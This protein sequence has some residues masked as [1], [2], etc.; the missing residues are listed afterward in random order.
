L[1]LAYGL[2]KDAYILSE[3]TDNTH[4]LIGLAGK[5]F[6][7]TGGIAS[8]NQNGQVSNEAGLR[9][10]VLRAKDCMAAYYPDIFYK[11]PVD[12]FRICYPTSRFARVNPQ[13][14]GAIQIA[15][16]LNEL[17]ENMRTE[18]LRLTRMSSATPSLV[19]NEIKVSAIESDIGRMLHADAGTTSLR[20]KL[21]YKEAAVTS[22]LQ[23]YE[24]KNSIFSRKRLMAEALMSGEAEPVID[25]DLS[26]TCPDVVASDISLYREALIAKAAEYPIRHILISLDYSLFSGMYAEVTIFFDGDIAAGAVALANEFG[27]C[28]ASIAKGGGFFI[29]YNEKPNQLTGRFEIKDADAFNCLIFILKC[30]AKKDQFFFPKSAAGIQTFFWDQIPVEVNDGV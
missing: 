5:V 27:E 13:K 26:H 14:D 30:A 22:A 17:A 10:L 21:M 4:V 7:S 25:I 20:L 28:W 15:N 24:V 6:S 11:P 8:L 1:R 2:K 19:K 3:G 12:A 29:N 9:N 23:A 16:A 18:T